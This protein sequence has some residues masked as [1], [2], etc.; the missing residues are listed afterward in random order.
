VSKYVI[1][2]S[3]QRRGPRPIHGPARGP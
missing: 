3:A 2:A 1:T